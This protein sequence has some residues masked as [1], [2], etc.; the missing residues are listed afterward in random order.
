VSVNAEKAIM[1]A[2]DLILF[3]GG[4]SGIAYQQITNNVNP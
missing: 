3:A 2:K 4:M 1:V